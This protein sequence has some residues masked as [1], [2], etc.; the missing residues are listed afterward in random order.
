MHNNNKVNQATKKGKFKR[1]ELGYRSG[2][3]AGSEPEWSERTAG[4]AVGLQVPAVLV[5]LWP[6]SIALRTQSTGL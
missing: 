5:W 1:K 4:V 3:A 2:S 6:G